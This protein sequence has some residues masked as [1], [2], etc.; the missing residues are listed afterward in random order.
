VIGLAGSLVF[1]LLQPA[2]YS[3][4]TKLWIDRTAI[5]APPIQNQYISAADE[6]AAV[7]QELIK[8]R[9]F[10]IKVARR[11]PLADDLRHSSGSDLVT[12]ALTA[13]GLRHPRAL[14]DADLGDLIYSTLT[15]HVIVDSSGPQIV[16]VTFDYANARV[17]G[18]TVG[19]IVDQFLEEVLGSH[20]A[21]VQSTV[22]FYTQQTAAAESD[23]AK[24]DQAVFQYIDAHPEQAKLGTA[25]DATLIQ[26]QR[27]DELA[28]QRYTAI[29]Q[30]LDQAQL[31]AAALKYSLPDGFRI[32]D[33]AEIPRQPLSPIKLV[34]GAAAGGL[35]AGLLLA[36]L[37]LLVLTMADS[38]LH[39]AE[40]V[41]QLLG[42]RVVGLVKKA[43]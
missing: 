23:L 28:R 13:T 15:K 34:A 21:Q 31:D 22:D 20:R 6:Q 4:S 24:G 40:E 5:G 8:T 27:E 42:L 26:L 37:A 29:L 38:S 36:L 7:L 3:A 2:S 11:S 9:S 33:P 14:S 12:R 17:A 19:A 41:E 35:G 18:L 1:V 39:R 30:K 32:I 43:S 10:C 16:T 25:P